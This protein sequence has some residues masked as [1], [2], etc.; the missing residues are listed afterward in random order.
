MLRVVF[1]SVL[2][3]CTTARAVHK[4]SV[5]LHTKVIDL[6]KTAENLETNDDKPTENELEVANTNRLF[7]W[8]PSSN[9]VGFGGLESE[10]P[11]NTPESSEDHS[12]NPQPMSTKQLDDLLRDLSKNDKE[13]Q[14]ADVAE[15]IDD[16]TP[17]EQNNNERMF[18]EDD[19]DADSMLAAEEDK[20]TNQ[21]DGIFQKLQE[22]APIPDMLNRLGSSDSGEESVENIPS[23]TESEQREPQLQSN[24]SKHEEPLN[25]MDADSW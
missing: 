22:T 18:E 23:E 21:N 13:K 14:R 9:V 8:V 6:E 12:V 10:T 4:H 7:E 19:G 5:S 2:I 1:V 15:E 25:Y 20:S 3:V 11:E 16:E 17:P 24:P